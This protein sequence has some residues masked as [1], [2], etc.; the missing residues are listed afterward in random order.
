MKR[1]FVFSFIKE[2]PLNLIHI[3]YKSKWFVLQFSFSRISAITCIQKEREALLQF[4]NSFE[5][6]SHRLASWSETNCCSWFG[7]GCNQ[8]TGHVTMIDLWNNRFDFDSLALY[9]NPIDSSLFE[10][11][12][13]NYLDL[14]GNDFGFTQIPYFFCSMVELTYLN[15]SYASLDTTSLPHHL[16]N[17]TKL[18][19]LD[20]S[21]QYSISG[22]G[23]KQLNRD[24]E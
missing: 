23:L 12:Y 16:W 21:H 24:V 19:V 5:D 14:S 4:K 1:K 9:S 15:L 17:L 2:P 18:V 13:L 8:T 22:V 7:V 11:K 3:L 20:L 6:P 10:L